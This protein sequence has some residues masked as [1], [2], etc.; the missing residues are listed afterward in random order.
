MSNKSDLQCLCNS[1]PFLFQIKTKEK[2]E[3]K[4]KFR[5]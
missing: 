2:R 1:L 5:E 3:T 4:E